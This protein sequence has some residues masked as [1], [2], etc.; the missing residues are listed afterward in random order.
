MKI[1]TI[2]LIVLLLT[3][4]LS[5]KKGKGL[6]APTG[7]IKYYQNIKNKI[8]EIL[9]NKENLNQFTL[10]VLSAYYIQADQIEANINAFKDALDSCFLYEGVKNH[11]RAFVEQLNDSEFVNEQKCI[12][13][14]F[15]Y[16]YTTYTKF[17]SW[18][19]YMSSYFKI[20]NYCDFNETSDC[21]L[22]DDIQSCDV[23]DFLKHFFKLFYEFKDPLIDVYNCLYSV[24]TLVTQE[25][26]TD[27]NL[28]SA[29]SYQQLLSH[30]YP[31]ILGFLSGGLTETFFMGEKL[32]NIIY[33]SYM[34]YYDTDR[35]VFFRIGQVV[36][37]ASKLFVFG[38]TKR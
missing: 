16:Y 24:E 15:Y 25:F 13:N 34:L 37:E 36:G 29:D 8:S 9:H 4:T 38:G 14:K 3:T 27:L 12:Y 32:W 33:I 6:T 2:I 11:F 20:T 10:G 1:K 5:K 30:T 26:Y 21:E 18:K 22:L 7:K 17:T 35:R 28:L 31:L 23:K 19:S